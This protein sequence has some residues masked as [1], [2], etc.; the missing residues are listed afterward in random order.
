MRRSSLV[1]TGVS[2][3]NGVGACRFLFFTNGRPILNPDWIRKVADLVEQR[4]TNVWYELG[5]AELAKELGLP[6]TL[7]RRNDTLDVWIDSGVSHE[8]VLRRHPALHWPADVY[9][10]ATD[11]HRGWF[12]SSLVTSVAH[13]RRRLPIERSSPTLSSWTWKAGKKSP[14]L[15]KEATPSQ[16]RRT[17]T[18]I[19]TA[20]ISSD[21]GF[22]ASTTPTRCHSVRRCL[23]S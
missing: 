19:S 14:S 6:E 13:Q 12:Q 1:R 15:S 4:G 11:Q 2:R 8:A 18:S 22:Q 17:I 9:I 16:P 10:E 20:Q 21:Y 7:S 23:T 5:D 3:D